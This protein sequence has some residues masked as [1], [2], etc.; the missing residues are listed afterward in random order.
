M[1][2]TWTHK[3]PESWAANDATRYGPN[4][5]L[6]IVDVQS[7]FADP[8]GSLSV[9]DGAEIVPLLN[10]E[11]ER[12]LEA[13]SAVVYTQDWHPAH[14]PH[15]AQDGGIWPVHCVADSPGA[16]LHPDLIVK[17]PVIRKG[18]HGEDGYSG[19]SMRNPA[20]GVPVP[21][22]LDATLAKGGATRLV[23]C[24][25]ATDYCVKATAL[26]GVRL[27]YD[28]AVLLDGIRAVNLQPGDGDK[29]LD[30]MAEAGVTLVGVRAATAP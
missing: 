22:D 14:T 27:G 9:R 18:T 30:E 3:D 16:G 8:S 1:A 17:G 4:V 11:I 5:A 26:D 25:L 29:A 15:F 12:A 13:G 24:G 7:D 6:V 2:G 28:T 21:T 10:A 20:G 19:F 23:V